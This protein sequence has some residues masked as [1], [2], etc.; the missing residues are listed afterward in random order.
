LLDQAR[1]AGVGNLIADET[2]WRAGLSPERPAGSLTPP[3]LRKLHRHLRAT[4]DAFVEG[5]GSHLGE[6]MAERRR[7]GHCPKDGTPLARTTVG[8]RTTFW[9]P[10]HQR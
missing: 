4:I 8:T 7:G 6:L 3:E 9:C 5:G 1:L 2:L 10:A